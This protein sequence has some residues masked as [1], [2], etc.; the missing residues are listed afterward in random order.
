VTQGLLDTSVVIA[1]GEGA[2]LELPDDVAVSAMTLGELHVGVLVAGT[3]AARSSRL[4]LLGAVEGSI[5]TIPI[6]ARVAR[7]FGRLVAEA[8]RGG[9]R[10]GV[11][12]ALIAAT[13]LANDLPL[14]TLDDDFSGVDGLEVVNPARPA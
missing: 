4:A 3:D 2:T 9:R 12:D 8:R 1:I 14:V 13:A 7:A 10:P 5:D 6:D 11:A